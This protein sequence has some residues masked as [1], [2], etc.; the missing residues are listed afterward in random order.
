MLESG[1]LN[2]KDW[3]FFFRQTSRDSGASSSLPISTNVT[4]ETIDLRE[5]INAPVNVVTMQVVAAA[6]SVK[7]NP[8]PPVVDIPEPPEPI[9]EE[10]P[11]QVDVEF[12]PEPQE[13]EETPNEFPL[14]L[15]AFG[16]GLL[17]LLAIGT[18]IYRR[19]TR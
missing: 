11:E 5:K 4:T 8:S 10:S 9:V 2:Y 7:S 16:A 3:K 14:G 12:I 6:S 19:R 15:I 18:I 1:D 13:P 17:I